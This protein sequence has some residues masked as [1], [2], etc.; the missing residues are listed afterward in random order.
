MNI[1]QQQIEKRDSVQFFVELSLVLVVSEV[2]FILS[3]PSKGWLTPLHPGSHS[4]SL[5]EKKVCLLLDLAIMHAVMQHIN[6][7]IKSAVS[8]MSSSVERS[9]Y[10]DLTVSIGS[11][12]VRLLSSIVCNSL[13]E[14]LLLEVVSSK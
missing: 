7:M 9:V 13:L 5:F 6:N 1:L 2:L 3:K 11:N 14:A 12:V 8:K 10:S 4:I